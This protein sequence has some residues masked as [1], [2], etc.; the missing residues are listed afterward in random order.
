MAWLIK[1]PVLSLV[2]VFATY[3]IFGWNVGLSASSLAHSLVEQGKTWQWLLDEQTVFLG[4]HILAGVLVLSITASLIAPVALIT[5]VFGSGF[6]SDNRAMVSVLLWAFAVV[7][8]IC[9]LQYFVRL[10]VLLCAATLGKLELQNQGYPQWKV[11]LIL[12][13]VCLGGFGLGLLTFYGHTQGAI[14]L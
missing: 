7:F 2:V 11:I 1:F 14:F 6:K 13:I 9:W 12:M 4:L 5:I 10:L 8:M 3:C